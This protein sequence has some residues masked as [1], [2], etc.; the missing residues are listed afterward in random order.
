MGPLP[1]VA[2]ISLSSWYWVGFVDSPAS[3]A[4]F[5]AACN[6]AQV[7]T[8]FGVSTLVAGASASPTSSRLP[9]SRSRFRSRFPTP[10]SA[11]K[12]GSPSLPSSTISNS[13]DRFWASPSTPPIL[14]SISM[15]PS[16]VSSGK[17]SFVS[18]NDDG[19]IA[20]AITS[21]NS[22]HAQCFIW[23][24][25]YTVRIPGWLYCTP[26]CKN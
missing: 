20:S 6:P 17:P 24:S 19:S 13:P 16:M 8:V 2:V 22:F 5:R 14:P 23:F 10:G 15:G 26:F 18:A 3:G 4:S 9:A 12:S 1:S 11:P 25:P 7:E 21:A